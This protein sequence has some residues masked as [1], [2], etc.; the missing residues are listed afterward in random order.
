[1]KCFHCGAP[2]VFELVATDVVGLPY[3][4]ACV[5]PAELDL[6]AASLRVERRRLVDCA[7]CGASVE[8]A[9]LSGLELAYP[10][11]PPGAVCVFCAPGVSGE[12][13]VGDVQ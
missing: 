12:G 7:V 8:S 4:D 13:K 6:R 5:G 1:M 9:L 11:G 3:C 10:E 2:A